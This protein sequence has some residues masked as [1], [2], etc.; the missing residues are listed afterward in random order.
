MNAAMSPPVAQRFREV[1]EA[2][3]NDGGQ[4]FL[5]AVCADTGAALV[6]IVSPDVNEEPMPMVI[7]PMAVRDSKG[8][9]Q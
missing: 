1:R 8:L 7:D 2:V 6:L 9:L 5:V 3:E 4:L